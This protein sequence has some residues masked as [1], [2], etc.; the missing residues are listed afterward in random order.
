ME[1]VSLDDVHG[2]FARQLYR[3][4]GRKDDD[5]FDELL[6]KEA[7]RAALKYIHRPDSPIQI[8]AAYYA[9]EILRRQPFSRLNVL[10]ARDIA[11]EFLIKNGW[12]LQAG[13]LI[14]LENF[15]N[16][17]IHDEQI[18]EWFIRNARPQESTGTYEEAVRKDAFLL[19]GL[20]EGRFFTTEELVSEAGGFLTV[21][22]L[23][24][25]IKVRIP[26]HDNRIAT[27]IRISPF[28][29]KSKSVLYRYDDD[30]REGWHVMDPDLSYDW[31]I[32]GP[33]EDEDVHTDTETYDESTALKEATVYV[34]EELETVD[35]KILPEEEI[36]DAYKRWVARGY[37]YMDHGYKPDSYAIFAQTHKIGN[38]PPTA[39]VRGIEVSICL[40]TAVD[41]S[42]TLYPMNRIL[43]VSVAAYATPVDAEL[44]LKALFTRARE[45][46]LP[47][48]QATDALKGSVTGTWTDFIDLFRPVEHEDVHT[49][50]GDDYLESRTNVSEI[51]KKTV[52]APP[53]SGTGLPKL[54]VKRSEMDE[55]HREDFNSIYYEVEPYS[56]KIGRA[57]LS[58]GIIVFKAKCFPNGTSENPYEDENAV[59][60]LDGPP[61]YALTI[62]LSV[63]PGRGQS[64]PFHVKRYFDASGTLCWAKGFAKGVNAFLEI[65][66]PMGDL[67]N[68][69]S[70]AF[71]GTHPK[72]HGYFVALAS[73]SVSD[74]IGTEAAKMNLW[75]AFNPLV[76]ELARR[77]EVVELEAPFTTV[78]HE[79]VHTDLGDA[80]GE[81]KNGLSSHLA[82]PLRD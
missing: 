22:D 1:I 42:V 82:R 52:Y 78:E 6:V 17:R 74:M 13:G 5:E 63:I 67:P 48:A 12:K 57:A 55:Q 58:N 38:L 50:V 64:I 21:A 65:F 14:L 44:V 18:I 11:V 8:T 73:G 69:E 54:T 56:F 59:R 9:I 36:A 71:G 81:A 27:I 45:N 35:L 70:R 53:K 75:Q 4:G 15:I 23:E 39:S 49:D 72:T 29:N 32:V 26:R 77:P 68:M 34:P 80:Y 41:V 25:G 79:D 7:F 24:P 40:S 51:R 76:R 62:G 66:C 20:T 10:M 28:G 30:G 60:P 19:A 37:P 46:G 31:Q 16:G 2:L 33:V 43:Q 61:F 47:L 3:A